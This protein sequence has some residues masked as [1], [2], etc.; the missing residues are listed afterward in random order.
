MP[1]RLSQRL[2]GV[3]WRRYRS[4]R[5]P[6]QPWAGRLGRHW[7][8]LLVGVAAGVG[9]GIV[10]SHAKREPIDYT[11]SARVLVT[12]AEEPYLR[13]SVTST[14]TRPAGS[15]DDQATEV[16]TDTNPPDTRTLVSAANLYPI[17]IES[18][19]V[20]EERERLFGSTPG[21]VEARTLYSVQTPNRFEASSIPVIE[22]RGTARSGADAVA[23]ADETVAAFRAWIE[24][25]QDQADVKRDQRILIEPLQAAQVVSTTGGPVYGIPALLGIA[26]FLAF[27]ALAVTLDSL[28]RRPALPGLTPRDQSSAP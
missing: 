9:V 15:G 21:T 18:D 2:R 25:R 11:A 28:R 1:E 24:A 5:G 6:G 20:R 14:S 8:I 22:I 23:L 19:P 4:S 10:T 7:W 27:G 26:V 13:V 16:I 17:L 3:D 12:S